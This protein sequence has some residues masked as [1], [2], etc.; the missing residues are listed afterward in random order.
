[1]TVA[2]SSLL[3]HARMCAGTISLLIDILHFLPTVGQ[4][5]KSVTKE[6]EAGKSYQPALLNRE[7]KGSLC[8]EIH[9]QAKLHELGWLLMGN[10]FFSQ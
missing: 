9:I 2:L 1:M 4:L 7:Q 10:H 6:K 5:E 3:A 8:E